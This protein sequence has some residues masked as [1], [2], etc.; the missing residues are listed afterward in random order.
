MVAADQRKG[1]FWKA[2]G[3]DARTG[4]KRRAE[5]WV[6]KK[7][8]PGGQVLAAVARDEKKYES[9]WEEEIPSCRFL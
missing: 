7:E 4:A 9:K 3:S 5:L 1:N 2:E 8:S 6:W